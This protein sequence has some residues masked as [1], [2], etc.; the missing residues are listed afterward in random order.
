MA[1]AESALP[2]GMNFAHPDY[3]HTV[4]ILALV[5]VLSD[6]SLGKQHKDATKVERCARRLAFP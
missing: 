1:Q 6:R 5:S 4:A 2:R 3:Y